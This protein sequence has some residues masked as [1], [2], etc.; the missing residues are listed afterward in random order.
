MSGYQWL[1]LGLCFLIVAADGMDVAIMGFVA[2]TILQEWGIS[3]AA[4]GMVMSAAPIGLVVGALLAGPASD[5]VGRKKVLVGSVLAFALFTLAASYAHNVTE[6]MGLR[7]L[8]GIGLGAAMPNTTTLLSE[9][10]PEKSR[11]LMVTMMF[12]GFNL[13][14]ALVGF[15]A[16]SLIPVYGWRAVLVA[17]GLVPLALVPLLMLLLPESSRF[18]AVRG[19]PAQRIAR[20]LG[21]VCGATF[22]AGTA[23][24]SQEPETPAKTP[25][26]L[27]FS[28]GFGL[29]SGALWLTYF[30]GLMVIYLLTGW[31]PTL[32][33]D[34][35][36][37][38]SQA[39]NMTAL[40]QIGG[41]VGGVFVG[42]LMDKRAPTRVISLGYL[43]GAASVLLLAYSGTMSAALGLLV[44]LVGFCMSGAQTGL[45]AY[46]PSCYP[47][48]ARA[49]GVSWMLGMG[50]FGSIF[51]S[52]IGGLLLGLGWSFETI[53]SLLAIP[54]A[55]AAGAVLLSRRAQA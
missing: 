31:L 53:L 41:T 35:G 47:T 46:A 7:F 4:F 36:L 9:Y 12:T 52:A 19:A 49:T 2:P 3:R 10:V 6:L 50:R 32:F 23:F 13:G 20:T 8:T 28:K 43:A 27:L 25:V 51:G 22:P 26:R 55:L 24:V 44:A 40:F 45:N 34:A 18:L 54:A 37:T 48:M 29:M 42:W 17:G 30:M 5:K 14:S 1:V 21:R 39:A 15:V 11:S 38:V 33:K 16:A